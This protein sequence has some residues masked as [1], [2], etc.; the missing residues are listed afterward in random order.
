[1]K[2][3][4]S[5]SV[6]THA[7]TRNATIVTFTSCS[8]LSRLRHAS[9]SVMSA[10]SLCVTC[11]IITQLRARFGAAIFWIRVRG[12]RSIGPYFAKS[13]DGQGASERPK[14]R[15]AGEAVAGPLS[16]NPSTSAFVIRPL[17]PG[18]R[19]RVRST[20]RSRASRRTEGLA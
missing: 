19:D 13:T 10:S 20:P 5:F 16:M 9:S 8:A 18:A 6:A 14:P 3:G 2:F 4:N 1:M 11:G 17:R 7:T 15:P 12:T